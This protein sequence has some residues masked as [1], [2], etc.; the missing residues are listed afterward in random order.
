LRV[1]LVGAAGWANV[2]DDLIALSISNW[3]LKGGHQVKVVGG[4]F[5]AGELEV[6]PALSGSW[7]ARMKLVRS[8][9]AS[10]VVLIGGGGLLDDREPEFFRP[11][12]RVATVC[13]IFRRP[14]AFIGVGVGPVRTSEAGRLYA[15]ACNGAE[16]VMVRDT[17][18]LERLKCVGVVKEIQV[19]PDPV[20]W[21][22]PYDAAARP[23]RDVDL[24]INLR[25]WDTRTG[26]NSSMS[27]TEIADALRPVLDTLA[28]SGRTI[29]GFSMSSMRGDDDSEAIRLLLSGGNLQDIPIV[30]GAQ[31]VAELISRSETVVSMRLHGC[32]LAAR[33]G[34]RPI[35]LAYDKKLEQQG[36]AVGFDAIPLKTETVAR[37][38]MECL[39]SD[40]KPIVRATETPEF[41]F[42]T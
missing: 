1:L 42:R 28:A 20:M 35:G 31:A 3:A 39:M 18:S 37:Q 22:A 25:N 27:T 15:K 6:L 26:D 33:F 34:A 9:I 36:G 17:A 12:A 32:L 40:V 23:I 30:T 21:E 16:A 38:L 13:R 2:G 7:T 11:F 24:A 41:P 14:Y 29:V 5:P 8:I 4:P 10:D 19:V